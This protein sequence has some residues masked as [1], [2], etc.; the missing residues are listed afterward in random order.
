MD[1]R[2]DQDWYRVDVK[3]G[4][5]LAFDIEAEN[6][7]G[8]V[9]DASLT[10][11]DA[12]GKTLKYVDDGPRAD[13]AAQRDPKLTWTF[14]KGGTYY[15]K[16]E[17]LFKQ[18][19]PEQIYR[20]T[21]RE[22]EPD[23]RVAL[24]GG[25]LARTEPR[26]RFNVAQGGKTELTIALTRLDEFEGEVKVEV[27]GIAG[28]SDRCARDDRSQAASSQ[29]RPDSRSECAARRRRGGDR[30]DGADRRQDS[31]RALCYCRRMRA[32][33]VRVLGLP[34]LA[35]ARHGSAAVEVFARNSRRNHLH[36]ARPGGGRS[37]QSG[38]RAR[39]HV[40]R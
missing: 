25:Y 8:S 21:V 30:R 15:V 16:I 6:A 5:K 12:T 33:W 38:P 3:D 36:G 40:A 34:L 17:N 18:F 29:T 39:I 28:R 35:P 32:A 19:G 13:L 7:G 2:G 22:L 20:F 9:M 37:G 24:P 27:R 23:F 26:D 10:L 1:K 31:E 4:Q 14:E 11:T